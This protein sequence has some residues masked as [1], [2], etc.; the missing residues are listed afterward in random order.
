L[1]FRELQQFFR[2]RESI[3]ANPGLREAVSTVQESN[4]LS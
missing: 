4:G 3:H 2:D 1:Y